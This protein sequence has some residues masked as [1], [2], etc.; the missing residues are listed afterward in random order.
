M[1]DITL[2]ARIAEQSVMKML[3]AA[4]LEARRLEAPAGIAIVDPSGLLRAWVLM[5]DAVPLAADIVPKKARTAVFTGMPT[6]DMPV[7]LSTK[8]TVATADFVDLPGGLPIVVDGQVVG[9]IAAG[10]HSSEADVAIARAGLAALEPAVK[11]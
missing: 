9:G 4:V 7:D 3:K 2:S 6:G 8:L 10:A 5:D 11:V 1:S